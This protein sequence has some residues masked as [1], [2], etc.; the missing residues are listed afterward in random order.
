MQEFIDNKFRDYFREFVSSDKN[1]PKKRV[2]IIKKLKN[3]KILTKA[4]AEKITEILRQRD[5]VMHYTENTWK[6]FFE[7]VNKTQIDDTF[8]WPFNEN[9]A[10]DILDSSLNILSYASRKFKEIVDE[11][12]MI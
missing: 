10:K 11:A 4:K 1:R 2:D 12:T 5:Q 8:F 6:K 3:K 9:Q 7:D